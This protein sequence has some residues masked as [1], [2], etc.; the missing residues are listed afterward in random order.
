GGAVVTA[1]EGRAGS[2][3]LDGQQVDIRLPAKGV[4]NA[5]NAAGAL[6]A[7]SELLGPA[8]DP[9]LAA[10][11]LSAMPPV[12]GRGEITEVRGVPVEFVLVQNPASFQLNVDTLDEHLD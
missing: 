1:V 11:A 5:V 3:D 8:F 2:I 4:H 7:A 12:F 6:L 9:D 10:A